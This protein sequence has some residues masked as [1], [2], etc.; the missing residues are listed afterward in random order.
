MRKK[1]SIIL[2]IAGILVALSP[3]VG[4][5]YTKYQEDKMID[6]WLNSA[7][8]SDAEATS[9]ADPED[10]YSQLQE[11]F[12]S[13][14]DSTGQKAGT[15]GSTGAAI[16]SVNSGSKTGTAPKAS[17]Q[18]V[19]GVIQ[20]KKIKV[21]APIVEGVKSYNLSRAVGHIPGTAAVG[22]P[23]NCVIAGHRSYTFGKFFNRLDEIVEGDEIT[24]TTKK[25]DLTYKVSKI[26]VVKPDDVSVLKGS[27]DQNTIT[28]VTCTPVYV[29][30]H[31]L[32]VIADLTNRVLKVP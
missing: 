21:K 17:Q 14:S 7:D 4:Q 18:T 20:I 12:D 29:A 10:A 13:E 8:A 2:L 5:L 26:I 1:I 25:E 6:D 16:D 9:A 30:S 15:N 28:L 27:A 31:R 23:G 11:A 3:V 19:L 22:E 24:I 32:I